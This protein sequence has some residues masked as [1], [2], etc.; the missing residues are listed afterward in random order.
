M[1]SYS[2]FDLEVGDTILI[3]H[4]TLTLL[5]TEGELGLFQVDAA[6]DYRPVSGAEFCEMLAADAEFDASCLPAEVG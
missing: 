3:G 6:G 5:D 4:R 2:E 1:Q